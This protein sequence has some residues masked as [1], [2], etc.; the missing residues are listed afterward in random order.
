MMRLGRLLL[1]V[2]CALALGVGSATAADVGAATAPALVVGTGIDKIAVTSRFTG[3]ELLVFGALSHPGAV[4][5][6][7][8]SPPSAL[9][10]TQKVQ[11]GPIWLTGQKVTVQKLPGVVQIAASAP[12]ASLL[13]AQKRQQLGLDLG[14]LVARAQ[15]VPEPQDR[16]RWE[17]AV[18][19]AKERT[20]SFALKEHAVKISDG[21]LFSVRLDLPASLPLGR[22]SLTTYLIRDGQVLAQSDERIDVEQ[23]GLEQWVADVA[24]RE[25]W[26]FGIGLTLL[27]AVL[28][29]GLGIVMQRRSGS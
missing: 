11:T 9:A 10:V 6:V 22:Y 24:E 19:A 18:L 20:G 27:L 23:V 26:L 3:R 13:P 15:F 25:P 12:L 17:Q 2:F 7:L 1:P 4:V 16:R 28:G 5:V 14:D 29:L 8:R 21:R